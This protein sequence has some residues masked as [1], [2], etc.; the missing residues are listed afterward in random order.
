VVPHEQHDTRCDRNLA[1]FAHDTERNYGNRSKSMH[2]RLS[3]GR[4]VVAA[5]MVV[6]LAIMS[7]PSYGQVTSNVLR[8][9][10]LI[11]SPSGLGTAFTIEVDGRQYLITAKHVVGDLPNE[12]ESTIQILRKNGWSP[13]KV[14]IF[15]CDDP[16]DI[17]ILVPPAQLTVNYALEPTSKGLSIG[18]DAYFV[19]FPYGL[20][21]AKTYSTLPDVLGF[22]KKATVAQFDS[23]PEHNMQ[24]ILLDGYNNPGFSGSPLV[25]RDLS[26]NNSNGPV[27]KVAG[28]IVDY[29]SYTSPVMKKLEIQENEITANDRAKNDVLKTPDG[30]LYRLK[31]T[32]QIVKLN[33]GIATA[34]DI[35]TAVDLIRKHPIGPK[36][37]DNFT[38]EN[39]SI[40]P[41]SL[42]Q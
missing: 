8:R 22:V 33:T 13:V 42:G 38:G 18:Q 26:Q 17:A 19:G 37:N 5:F 20:R 30:R 32:G 4:I 41:H 27:F 24:R 39:A 31:D 34:W 35:G 11:Q 1:I 25:F 14:R 12:S 23:M 21:F 2:I 16:V 15:K 3:I 9:T 36:T 29:E 7:L 40:Q 10:L 6:A 28:V